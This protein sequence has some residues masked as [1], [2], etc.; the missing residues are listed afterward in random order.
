MMQHEGI[1]PDVV[2]FACILKACATI[3]A[4]DKGEQIHEEIARQGLLQNKLCWAMLYWTCMPSAVLFQRHNKCL[5]GYLLG[6]F[7][8][9]ALIAVSA[10]GQA[11]KALDCFEGMQCEG[12]LPDVVTYV[13]ILKA[14][15]T[16]RVVAKHRVGQCSCFGRK[17]V[18]TKYKSRKAGKL[19]KS[20]GS[21][22]R[23]DAKMITGRPRQLIFWQILISRRTHMKDLTF[24]TN[25]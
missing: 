19:Q 3:S 12:I 9:N 22:R 17:Q 14:C 4:D 2:T 7:S 20:Y 13:C 1:L 21:N 24:V 8:W 6:M 16:I 5:A 18:S 23:G 11:K 15:T 10:Q 25:L